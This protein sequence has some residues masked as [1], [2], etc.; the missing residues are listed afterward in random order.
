MGDIIR[1]DIKI[2]AVMTAPRYENTWCRNQIDFALRA[3]GIPFTVSGGVYYGQCMQKMLESAIDNGTEYAV[4]IDGDSVFKPEQLQRLISIAV[5]EAETIDAV[6]AMQVRR[7]QKTM[8]GT[9]AGKES[10]QWNGYPLKVDT[11]HFG[12]TVINL[13]KLAKTPKPWF[14]CQPD[15]NGQWGEDRIDSDIWFWRQWAAAGNSIHIDIATRIGHV[16][17]M[18]VT[19]NDDMRIEHVYPVD[20]VQQKEKEHDDKTCV[21]SGLAEKNEERID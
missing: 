15:A 5:Q 7:G 14:F 2:C 8:L 4:T 21:T 13:A 20:W 16:E 11:A 10:A 18:I 17:E 9:I 3:L 12:L 6:C 19:Y 1:K